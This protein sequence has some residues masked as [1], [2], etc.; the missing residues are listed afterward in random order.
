[1]FEIIPPGLR[2]NLVAWT[3]QAIWLSVLVIVIG[4][5]PCQD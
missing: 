1:M 2:L 5:V 4:L 3:K